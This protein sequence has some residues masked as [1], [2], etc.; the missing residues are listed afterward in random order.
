MLPDEQISRILAGASPIR[1]IREHRGL[2]LR[3]LA[4]RTGIPLADLKDYEAGK[5]A[6]S[7]GREQVVARALDVQPAAL[8]RCARFED[9]AE[10]LRFVDE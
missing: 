4:M 6:I 7:V 5:R 3:V 2:S 9:C 8:Q 1:V 10:Q